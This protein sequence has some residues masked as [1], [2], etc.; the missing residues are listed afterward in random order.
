MPLKHPEKAPITAEQSF[1]LGTKEGRDRINQGLRGDPQYAAYLQSIGG[2]PGGSLSDEQRKRAQAWVA[3]NIGPIGGLEIDAAGNLNN[4]HGFAQEFKQWGPVALAAGGI[5]AAPF[6]LPALAGGAAAAP[7]AS[8]VTALGAAPNI[9]TT[10][11]MA[12]AASLGWTAPSL[13]SALGSAPV[14]A[15]PLAS[16]AAPAMWTELMMN[17]QSVPGAVT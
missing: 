7:S 16:H 9:A 3:Q 2:N 10:A 6:I 5:A 14:A 12:N 1:A 4:P 15:A 17:P 11:G 13:A 8:A